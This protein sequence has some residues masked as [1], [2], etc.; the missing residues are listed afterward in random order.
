M[1]TVSS[2]LI[3]MDDDEPE[4]LPGKAAA[5]A[6][7][8]PQLAADALSFIV[9]PSAHDGN[10]QQLQ[11]QQ[12]QQ[13]HVPLPSQRPVLPGAFDD[14][15]AMF[16]TVA[17]AANHNNNNIIIATTTTT[18]SNNNMTTT[19]ANIDLT[20]VQVL[21]DELRRTAQLRALVLNGIGELETVAQLLVDSAWSF[22]TQTRQYT[23]VGSSSQ[24][25]VTYSASFTAAARDRTRIDALKR[26]LRAISFA[27][28]RTHFLALCEVAHAEL[29]LAHAVDRLDAAALPLD[30]RRR[31][32]DCLFDILSAD[33]GVGSSA[34]VRTASVVHELIAAVAAVSV[35]GGALEPIPPAYALERLDGCG[36]GAWGARWLFHCSAADVV[37]GGVIERMFAG[38]TATPPRIWAPSHYVALLGR[39]DWRAVTHVIAQADLHRVIEPLVAALNGLT[40]RPKFGHVTTIL[41][42]IL[43]LFAERH[44]VLLARV[45]DAL[46][47]APWPAR[48][49][50]LPF[51]ALLPWHFA[52]AALL[53]S[54]FVRLYELPPGLT[55]RAWAGTD[56]AAAAVR[57]AHRSEL[58]TRIERHIPVVQNVYQ[59]VP[60]LARALGFAAPDGAAAA[61]ASAAT[62][63]DDNDE[64]A[65]AATD[66]GDAGD[67]APPEASE[68]AAVATTLAASSGGAQQ[69]ASLGLVALFRVLGTLI[70]TDWH[71][72]ANTDKPPTLA[73]RAVDELCY[74]AFV[75]SQA[76]KSLW[77][78]RNESFLEL[79]RLV[80]AVPALMTLIVGSWVR[81]LPAVD[82]QGVVAFVG[83]VAP[84]LRRSWRPTHAVIDQLAWLLAHRQV[85][86][87]RASVE[88]LISAFVQGG[89]HVRFT[90]DQMQRGF[91]IGRAVAEAIVWR[92]Q[93]QRMR[94]N[95]LCVLIGSDTQLPP[96]WACAAI[97]GDEFGGALIAGMQDYW[98][99]L[100]LS[101]PPRSFGASVAQMQ[102]AFAVGAQQPVPVEWLVQWGLLQRIDNLTQSP[103]FDEV[104][105]LLIERLLRL[106]LGPIDTAT[107]ERVVPNWL[108]TIAWR[109]AFAVQTLI[110]R[111][112]RRGGERWRMLWSRLLASTPL[113]IGRSPMLPLLDAM[114]YSCL[115]AGAP[116][117]ALLRPTA[118]QRFSPQELINLVR[119]GAPWVAV[120]L[121]T[122]AADQAD[123]G[124]I[125]AVP[126]A[127][128]GASPSSSSSSSANAAKVKGKWLAQRARV[129]LKLGGDAEALL[130]ARAVAL[131]CGD[132]PMAFS[133]GIFAWDAFF[134]LL[135]ASRDN[136]LP[137][138]ERRALTAH[139]QQ[140]A[141][142]AGQARDEALRALFVSFASFSPQTIFGDA[143]S[144]L[145]ARDG[146]ILR[147]LLARAPAVLACG[148]EAPDE[149]PVAVAA[150]VVADSQRARILVPPFERVDAAPGDAAISLP[151]VRAG[152]RMRARIDALLDE[153]RAVP[154]DAAEIPLLSLAERFRALADR[155]VASVLFLADLDDRFIA[156]V[157]RMYVNVPHSRV[158]SVPSQR[159]AEPV[160]ITVLD[161]VAQDGG[162]TA[163][164]TANRAEVGKQLQ[165]LQQCARNLGAALLTLDA[166][167]E[168]VLDIE[169]VAAA[170][171]L[172]FSILESVVLADVLPP[173]SPALTDVIR[174]LMRLGELLRDASKP[175]DDNLLLLTS[176]AASSAS[177]SAAAASSPAR[178]IDVTQHESRLLGAF[179]RAS[180]QIDAGV[181]LPSAA[182]DERIPFGKSRADLF[183]LFSPLRVLPQDVG[184][185]RGWIAYLDMLGVLATSETDLGNNELL[186]LAGRFDV[187]NTVARMLREPGAPS[188]Q[189]IV[190]VGAGLLRTDALAPSGVALFEQL[191]LFDFARN[192]TPVLNLLLRLAGSGR[193]VACAWQ[194]VFPSEQMAALAPDVIQQLAALLCEH[195]PLPDAHAKAALL[196]M[197]ALL[198]GTRLQQH[199][200]VQAVWVYIYRLFDACLRGE[201]ESGEALALSE[202]NF[203]RAISLLTD[204]TRSAPTTV[205]CVWPLL[206]S[207][208]LPRLAAAAESSDGEL[209]AWSNA[210]VTL[211][212]RL[213]W[214]A[215]TFHVVSADA[216]RA[217]LTDVRE[218]RL[219]ARVLAGGLDW[220]AARRWLTPE[221]DDA[222]F[223]TVAASLLRYVLQLEFVDRA[224]ATPALLALVQGDGALAWSRVLEATFRA[225][226][227]NCVLTLMVASPREPT[228][229]V[230]AAVRLL[231]AVA[232][233]APALRAHCAR[234]IRA[235]L[236]VVLESG[237]D[238]AGRRARWHLPLDVHEA[239][240]REAL[241]PLCSADFGVASTSASMAAASRGDESGEDASVHALLSCT[242]GRP[243]LAHSSSVRYA[244]VTLDEV[245]AGDEM[246]LA[247]DAP[248][249]LAARGNAAPGVQSFERRLETTLTGFCASAPAVICLR[250]LRT[251][252]TACKDVDELVRLF[253]AALHGYFA[254]VASSG[255]AVDAEGG[256]LVH[257]VATLG[258]MGRAVC[259]SRLTACSKGSCALTLR[260]LLEWLRVRPTA[261]WRDTAGLIRL[262][263][264]FEPSRHHVFDVLTLWFFVLDRF[265]DARWAG[266]EPQFHDELWTAFSR[267]LQ[268]FSGVAIVGTGANLKA[269]I[270]A[271]R[272]KLSGDLTPRM[273]LAAVAV[274]AFAA[275]LLRA[276]SPSADGAAALNGE[277]QQAMN[278]LEQWRLST[279]F[280]G[281]DRFFAMMT[282]VDAPLFTLQDFQKQLSQT[283]VP[284]APY[285][286]FTVWIG[287]AT[288]VVDVASPSRARA[289]SAPAAAADAAPPPAPAPAPAPAETVVAGP[290][291]GIL[292]DIF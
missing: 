129:A 72:Y 291:T 287:A 187:A 261:T 49:V 105:L 70:E 162:V 35:A 38:V 194:R 135:F 75:H 43:T 69:S 163:E 184:D 292:V 97:A 219:G 275:R 267:Y 167:V 197:R 65:G 119:N 282:Q 246:T 111:T 139:F 57:A 274:H 7:T 220:T 127:G 262:V 283:L 160:L 118:G 59:R 93:P 199:L 284:I 17:S 55:S 272:A 54:A 137:P 36:G 73:M 12:Q 104:T 25:R 34:S 228:A 175:R 50:A 109:A 100:L 2:K 31:L 264:A 203:E 232:I 92:D 15:D 145:A 271:T 71:L 153:A 227:D 148:A 63:D 66:L 251:G 210:C 51:I 169:D 224:L 213:P 166:A 288:P 136:V 41:V 120:A 150:A 24:E 176:S 152:R 171:A 13:E 98:I 266:T 48:A 249:W 21:S 173:D 91:V 207:R 22:P 231:A 238:A 285:L 30:K 223:S 242:K 39:V 68:K 265:A 64:A 86:T 258:G 214:A 205:D 280:R 11:Q 85:Q 117:D 4:A 40:A 33:D 81:E 155:R 235:P 234:M 121:L 270:D 230:Q 216:V 215:A 172:F 79:A 27:H 62:N 112:L 195:M 281:F 114:C 268:R 209:V 211:L 144:A 159:G 241:V 222:A 99:Q 142:R 177:A 236:F 276:R 183:A 94:F 16:G 161:N 140:L 47:L 84:V 133:V 256:P 254:Q 156:G 14:L 208:V 250:V 126:G 147:L 46:T 221:T 1:S 174:S 8:S 149:Q 185:G 225:E 170:R 95:M 113:V 259:E 87:E 243:L 181:E 269:R 128:G 28:D 229:A 180:A 82:P 206:K 286:E 88:D 186:S 56:G 247:G 6:S 67:D 182:R 141:E 23:A 179:L 101:L 257:A 237:A 78:L 168:R 103:Q 263:I 218:D 277:L 260:V 32:L 80:K 77:V 96:P 132:S 76:G 217:V 191:L 245:A 131:A 193:M 61:A 20:G 240:V 138:D 196:L 165:Q 201:R 58:A 37:A 74:F 244:S 26:Q 143:R 89:P 122:D 60:R 202:R 279:E 212:S 125:G 44:T 198:L 130:N 252:S 158:V 18:S 9:L 226:L 53:R 52:D 188:V 110:Q 115:C 189:T 19:T 90:P 10:H 83:Y 29:R 204:V 5:A 164:L 151:A 124:E 278:Q 248:L 253:E 200:H 233:K 134:R 289:A 123:G 239:V 116:L 192:V 290:A 102:L 108:T 255:A 190:E 106:A 154:L 45:F 273:R 42:H 3:D 107:I 157:E 178:L 146:A